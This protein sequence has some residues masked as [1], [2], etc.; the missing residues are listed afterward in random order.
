MGSS[1]GHPFY[2]NQY[3]KSDY[4]I[5]SFKYVPETIQSLVKSN[6][7]VVH[8]AKGKISDTVRFSELIENVSSH[9]ALKKG[10]LG[11]AGIC[12]VSTL[13]Y[14]HLSKKKGSGTKVDKLSQDKSNRKL[15]YNNEGSMNYTLNK[16]VFIL[17]D[18]LKAG[19]ESVDIS[20]YTHIRAYHGCRPIAI[21]DYY[22]KG[23]LPISA[24][25]AENDVIIRLSGNG[26]TDEKIIEM[27]EDE[28]F[29]V[30][31]IHKK[32]WLALSKDELLGTCGHYV[33]Y[34]SEFNY[35][36]AAKLGI[37][38]QL[39]KVG[40]PTIFACDI[41]IINITE[42]YLDCINNLLKNK[43]RNAGVSVKG[44]VHSSE[45]VE[46]VH[47]KKIYDPILGYT[48]KL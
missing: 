48:R 6:D 2:G 44:I 45:I 25:S 46:H 33:I 12:L 40:F 31:N 19:V 18:L 21:D 43:D 47:P 3:V 23:I 15:S 4:E 13:A 30:D 38:E 36:V 42:G 14:S 22:D 16:K 9:A 34:G 17:D 28:W 5:G 27:F 1:K 11:V 41:P 37:Q 29:S 39:T 24:E 8:N 32:V 35:V 20:T 7:V 26:V 10:I